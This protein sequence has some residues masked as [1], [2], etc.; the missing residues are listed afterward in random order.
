MG[1]DLFPLNFPPELAR[2]A[3]I[4]GGEAAWPPRPASMAVE[5]FAAHGFAVLGTELW[6]LQ[7]GAIQSLPVGLS[8][9][10]EVHGNT[11]ERGVEEAWSA[12]VSRANAETIAYL[13]SFQ[14][15][16]I[17]EEGEVYFNVVWVSEADLESLK[18]RSASDCNAKLQN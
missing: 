17:V 12:F 18:Q 6:L 1:G 14:F 8:G 7:N 3:F 10:R 15:A 2:E 16:E 13:Q 5:W 9:M 4:S 11:V